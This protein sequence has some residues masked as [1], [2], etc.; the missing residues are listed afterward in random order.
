[1]LIDIDS[2][3][4]HEHDGDVSGRDVLLR[5]LAAV[6]REEHLIAPGDGPS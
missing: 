4:P 2:G 1:M 6:S 5:W 3:K